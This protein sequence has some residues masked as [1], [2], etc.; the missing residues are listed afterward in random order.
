MRKIAP[1]AA[2]ALLAL[3]GCASTSAGA[4]PDTKTPAPTPSVEASAER[5][6]AVDTCYTAALDSV[7]DDYAGVVTEDM[8]LEKIWS[9]Q[10][11]P[12]DPTVATIPGGYSVLFEGSSREGGF[13]S[14]LCELVD[15]TATVTV[16]S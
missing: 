5:D 14:H 15:G 3:T 8:T 13:P 16:V 4:V 11:A 1:L 9:R 12:G 10:H 6:A 7:A 2:L